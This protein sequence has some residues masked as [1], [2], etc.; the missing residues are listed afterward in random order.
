MTRNDANGVGARDDADLWAALVAVDAV[1]PEDEGTVRAIREQDPLFDERVA[2]FRWDAAEF[3][4]SASTEPPAGLRASVLDSVADRAASGGRAPVVALHGDRSAASG[5]GDSGGSGGASTG[6]AGRSM[7]W[8]LVAAAA[9]LA[10]IVGGVV[11]MS[12]SDGGG[13]GDDGAVVAGPS[14]S[15]SP[16]TVVERADVAGGLVT[17]EIVEGHS[18]ATVHLAGVPAPDVGSAY[19]MWLVGE[20]SSRSVGVMGPGDVTDDMTMEIDGVDT[21][22]SLMISVEPPGGSARPTQALVDIPLRG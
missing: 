9:S 6:G 5:R 18:E 20:G 21:A 12:T 19:Q 13:S 16:S 4:S 3:A 7:S 2:R 8:G 11:W 17:V 14:E 22:D 1:D 10:V 15:P